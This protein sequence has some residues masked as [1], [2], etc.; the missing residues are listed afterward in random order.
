MFG[1]LSSPRGGKSNQHGPVTHMHTFSSES[2]EGTNNTTTITSKNSRANTN[3]HFASI[4]KHEKAFFVPVFPSEHGLVGVLNLSRHCFEATKKKNRVSFVFFFSST[5][6]LLFVFCIFLNILLWGMRP[7]NT[8]RR[9]WRRHVRPKPGRRSTVATAG[10]IAKTMCCSIPYATTRFCSSETFR[11]VSSSLS[12]P[13]ITMHTPTNRSAEG[14]LQTDLK[15]CRPAAA[16]LVLVCIQMMTTTTTKINTR[17]SQLFFD[18]TLACWSDGAWMHP[19]GRIGKRTVS[20]LELHARCWIW[21]LCLKA[22]RCWRCANV[23]LLEMLWRNCRTYIKR[24]MNI[25]RKLH[26]IFF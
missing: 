6:R 19:V 14:I 18:G 5:V 24:W 10:N 8:A 26:V 22:N 16:T 3:K 1:L 2:T 15:G 9:H 20:V 17:I 13:E 25:D 7:V 11:I 4:F 12:N 23:V 21:E